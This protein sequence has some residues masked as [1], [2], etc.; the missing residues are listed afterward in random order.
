MTNGTLTS[1]ME[2][3]YDEES[4]AILVH[5][6][7]AAGE[8]EW[9]EPSWGSLSE[10]EQDEL[11]AIGTE[12]NAAKDAGERWVDVAIVEEATEDEWAGMDYPAF[13]QATSN[14]NSPSFPDCG[15]Y[16]EVALHAAWNA[17]QKALERSNA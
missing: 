12:V 15:E 8:V 5:G 3:Q 2:W 9:L 17:L 10:A 7:N 1:G 6:K 14:A 13:K 4:G 16:W 11:S